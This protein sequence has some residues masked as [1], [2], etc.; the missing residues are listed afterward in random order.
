MI[1][2]LEPGATDAQRE[3]LL[4]DLKTRGYGGNRGATGAKINKS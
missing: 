2:I 4:A 1:I 3:D